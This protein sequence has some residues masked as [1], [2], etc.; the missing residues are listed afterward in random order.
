MTGRIVFVLA[1]NADGVDAAAVPVAAAG[2]VVGLTGHAEVVRP[3]DL[4]D[5]GAAGADH[6]EVWGTHDWSHISSSRSRGC[7]SLGTVTATWAQRGR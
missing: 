7:L 5:D 3:V 1:G 4:D 2:M 6:D